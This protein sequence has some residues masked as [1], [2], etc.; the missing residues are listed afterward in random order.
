MVG[1]PSAA[2]NLRKELLPFF[3]YAIKSLRLD[4]V[5]PID[6]AA[7]IKVPKGG[8][9]TWSEE[10][11]AQYRDHHAVGTS[12]RLALEIFLWTAQRR[13]DASGF[14]RKHIRDGMI[15]V[16]PA[17]TASSSGKTVWLPVAP[18]CSKR[19]RRCR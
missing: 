4:R 2:N 17:K 1:G 12:A 14:G 5:N 16:T 18:S 3:A 8:F 19:S 11:I 10:E 13:G 15:E 6:Q 9:H 7:S